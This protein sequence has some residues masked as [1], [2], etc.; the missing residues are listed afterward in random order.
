M[1]SC[2]TRVAICWRK[3]QTALSPPLAPS[4]SPRSLQRSATDV[5]PHSSQLSRRGL[6]TSGHAMAGGK[7][8]ATLCR[9]S[10]SDKSRPKSQARRPSCGVRR[11][12]EGPVNGRKKAS[13]PSSSQQRPPTWR[14]TMPAGPR[15][16]DNARFLGRPS[17]M[18]SVV[19]KL[20]TSPRKRR[21]VS[22]MAG[23]HKG[24]RCRKIPATKR[25]TSTGNLSK[26]PRAWSSG[27]ASK[28]KL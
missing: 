14:S 9:V 8:S 3:T 13:G 27:C 5:R 12:P 15:A 28:K 22:D 17:A 26:L 10:L 2:M 16:K 4:S 1:Y 18:A 11:K 20:A 7:K 24:A 21:V 19:S 25:W 23:A 6:E